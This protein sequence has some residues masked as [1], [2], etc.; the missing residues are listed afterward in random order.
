VD[1]KTHHGLSTLNPLASQRASIELPGAHAKVHLH[2]NDPSIY[3]SLEATDD[4]EKVLSHA[5]TVSTNNAK[6]AANRKHGAHSPQSGFAIVKVDERKAVRVVGAIHISPTGNV[7]Q[8]EDV[9]PMKVEMMPGKHWMKLTPTQPLE[10]GEYAL[11]EIISPSDINQM[12]WDF[13][14]DPRYGDNEGSL[15]PILKQ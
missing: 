7:T 3:V 1:A 6:E 5:M 4:A 14:V 8:S 2:I 12:V 15:T 10:I 9:I 11:V 13:R